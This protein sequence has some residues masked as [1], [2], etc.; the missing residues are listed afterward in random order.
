M[1]VNGILGGKPGLRNTTV[2]VAAQANFTIRLAPG[3]QVETIAA[4]AERLLREVAP[5]GTDVELESEGSPA[6]FV[7]PETPVVQA[8]FEVFERV[9]EKRPVI[10]RVGG[11][12]PIYPALVDAGI[13]TVLTGIALPE[14]NVHSPNERLLLEFVPLGMRAARELY[15]SLAQL[16][17]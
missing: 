2:P 16:P 6:G 4:T 3:Q 17:T 10:T 13:P 7:P 12:L 8:A 11:T 9:F 1:D 14:S 5:P 15:L